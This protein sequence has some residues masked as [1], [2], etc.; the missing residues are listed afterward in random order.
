MCFFS[1]WWQIRK[2]A[3]RDVI[4]AFDIKNFLDLTGIQKC[5]INRANVV[6]L[7]KHIK[8]MAKFIINKTDV[9][10]KC[11]ACLCSISESYC[12]CSLSCW[13]LHSHNFSQLFFFFLASLEFVTLFGLIKKLVE[14]KMENKLRRWGSYGSNFPG[15]H[16][17]L[18]FNIVVVVVV[19]I[20]VVIAIHVVVVVAIHI[21]VVVVSI[22]IIM[23]NK[24]IHVISWN[25]LTFD[26]DLRY[27]EDNGWLKALLEDN[28]FE[29]CELH[30]DCPKYGCNMYFLD[31]MNGA[32]CTISI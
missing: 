4:R 3:T 9:N 18:K 15:N 13:I 6:F 31:C 17:K 8:R 25:M 26:F 32:L 5:I 22:L 27:E 24:V 28:F 21:V 30:C 10:N 2:P 11:E 20:H 12:F 1:L 19:V 16:V 23:R 14:K 29:T 7:R